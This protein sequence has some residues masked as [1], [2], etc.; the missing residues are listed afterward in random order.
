[1]Q[2]HKNNKPNS[3]FR[4]VQ[5]AGFY[6]KTRKRDGATYFQSAR[7]GNIRYLLLPSD[8]AGTENERGYAEPDFSLFVVP[9]IEG[10]QA[11]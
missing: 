6:S 1:M 7:V 5:I 10:E 4:G 9:I 8:K 3:V 2:N 11:E